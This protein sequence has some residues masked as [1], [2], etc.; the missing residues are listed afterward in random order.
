[1]VAPY[2]IS[3]DWEEPQDL[4]E[5]LQE[6]RLQR[7]AANLRKIRFAYFVAEKAHLG[8]TRNSGEAYIFH[9]LAVARILVD[10]RMDDDTICAALLHDVL[11]DTE[12]TAEELKSE[13]GDDVVQLVEGVTKLTF[14]DQ[15]ELSDRQ[16]V[17]AETTRTAE[18]LRKML[19]AM[20]KDFRVMVIK[21][22][23]RL[24]N[25]QT[26]DA[27]SPQRKARIANETLNVYAPLAAR[28][29]I[30]QIKWQLEDLSF[31]FLH[32]EEFQR[33]GDLVA[34]TRGEREADLQSA[35]LAIKGRFEERKLS[36]V[37][38][39]GRPKHLYSIFNKIVKQ[40]IDFS[41][42]YDLQ[43]LRIIVETVPDC[44]VA[45]GI[46][47]EIWTPITSLFFDYIARPK[48]NG[49]QSLHT[50]VYGPNGQPLEVQ[51]RTVAMHEIA[52]FGVAAH[53]TYKE[54]KAALDETSKLTALRKQLF[55]WSSDSL[56]SSDY[57]RTLSTDLFG[58]Q[59]FVFTPLGDVIDLPAG[60]TPVDFAFRVHSQLGMTLVG[61]RINGQMAQLSTQLQNGDVCELI[62]RANASPS[63]DWLEFVKSP[64]TRSKLR[65]HFRR[66]SKTDDAAKG[67]I[68]LEKELRWLGLDPKKYIGEDK[69]QKL[70]VTFDSCENPVDLLARIGLG[71]I[72]VQSVISK[73]RGIVNDA[74]A[75]EQ[76]QLTHTREGKLSMSTKG[77]ESILVTRAKC[78][79]PIPGDDVVGYVTRGRGIV[80][81]RRVCPNAQAY[82]SSE[83]ERLLNY[84]WVPDGGVYQVSLRVLAVNRTGLLMD[85]TAI[86]GESKTNV[87][88][89]KVKSLPNTTAEI[90]MII[91]VRDTAHL[92][93]MM[94]KISHFGDV[95]SIM[96]MFGRATTK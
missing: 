40:G 36:V 86:L 39:R 56:V 49:Y 43:A 23:D 79:S 16:R 95:L 60:S 4:H 81:H 46:V 3:H 48:S 11:E 44:Y 66:I 74:P 93:L 29:G 13:F 42:I 9:P 1:M 22:A 26:L 87:T 50:K 54:G 5:L 47:H 7:D 18:T 30:W 34:K 25:M 35:I 57:L 68:S 91:D 2:E 45:L 27:L 84:D 8:Q 70:A 53:W 10:L 6:I 38:I 17:A 90:D 75:A 69:L 71:T 31:K 62:N 85:V 28:L 33:I 12:V 24:H 14:K 55:D 64:H 15:A 88:A 21:L 63:L 83:P 96:R 32:P 51:I 20:A 82:I 73:L 89:L 67:R 92:S 19:L 52:E 72:G 61:T 78:C 80:I 77:M 94:T 59:V 65:A 41:E 58:E 37:D 76:I